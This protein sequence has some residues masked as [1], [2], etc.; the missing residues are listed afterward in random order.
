MPRFDFQISLAALSSKDPRFSWGGQ[1]AADFDVVDY[2]RGRTS[3]FAKYQVIMGNQLRPFDPNQG[4]YTFEG[5]TSLRIHQIELAGVFHHLSRH[6]SD[7]ANTQ[8]LAFNAVGPRVMR[9]F[10]FDKTSL[11]VRG[12]IRKVVQHTFIDYSWTTGLYVIARRPVTTTA[13]FFGRADIERYGVHRAISGRSQQ[14]GGHLE[15][16][17]HLQGAQGAIELFSGWEQVVDAYP[18]ERAS[19]RWAFIGVRVA[20]K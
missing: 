7:R 10:R 11:D 13:S 19:R 12:D 18:L 16:G 1:A 20:R 4:N 17:L 5:A 3:V 2:V 6:L 15:I 14:N 9:Q 8:S